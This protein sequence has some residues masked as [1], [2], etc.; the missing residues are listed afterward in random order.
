MKVKVIRLA[1]RVGGVVEHSQEGLVDGGDGPPGA[2][3]TF[4]KQDCRTKPKNVGREQA[5]QPQRYCRKANA[6]FRFVGFLGIGVHGEKLRRSVPNFPDV[7]NDGGTKG[8]TI[9]GEVNDGLVEGFDRWPGPWMRQRKPRSRPYAENV[10]CNRCPEKQDGHGQTAAFSRLGR[11]RL[12]GVHVVR[13]QRDA[14]KRKSER[15]LCR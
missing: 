12:V 3:V 2:R 7:E 6:F 8:R 14:R 15:V 9:F 11:G 13:L 4:G 10:D 1:D 5:E